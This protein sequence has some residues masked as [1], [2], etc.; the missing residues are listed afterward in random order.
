MHDEI[1]RRL[2]GGNQSHAEIAQTWHAYI[3]LVGK[4]IGMRLN[5]IAISVQMS[6]DELQHYQPFLDRKQEAA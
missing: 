5:K 3:T 2:Y 6:E 1:K 4:Y